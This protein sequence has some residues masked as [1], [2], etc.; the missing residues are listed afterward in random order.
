VLEFAVIAKLP[1]VADLSDSRRLEFLAFDSGHGGTEIHRIPCGDGYGWYRS[2]RNNRHGS[3]P[4]R[5]AV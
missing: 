5:I 2:Y 3:L 1:L 4:E